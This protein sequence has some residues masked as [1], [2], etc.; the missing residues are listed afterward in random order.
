MKVRARRIPQSMF[1]R[2]L[3]IVA[4]AL[5]VLTCGAPNPPGG[6]GKPPAVAVDA[7]APPSR[8]PA[9]DAA[10][11][12]SAVRD[13]AP[14]DSAARDPSDRQRQRAGRRRH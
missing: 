8:P 3:G 12:D 10:A 1:T 2:T 5:G 9:P 7:G 11:M 14:I 4:I 6:P 13:S